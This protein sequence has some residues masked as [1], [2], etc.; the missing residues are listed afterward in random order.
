[1]ETNLPT[2]SVLVSSEESGTDNEKP[3]LEATETDLPTKSAIG[4]SKEPGTDNEQ[5]PKLEATD[6]PEQRTL[7]EVSIWNVSAYNR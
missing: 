5:Q 1:M 7:L 6:T 4:S 3:R 2:K